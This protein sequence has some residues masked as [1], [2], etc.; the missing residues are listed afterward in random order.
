MRQENAEG[1]QTR[2]RR[3]PKVFERVAQQ[4]FDFGRV[5]QNPDE[6][7]NASAFFDQIEF[8]EPLRVLLFLKVLMNLSDSDEP[9]GF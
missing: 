8:E 5:Y 1:H 7:K 3:S 6:E 2:S 4:F 9:F